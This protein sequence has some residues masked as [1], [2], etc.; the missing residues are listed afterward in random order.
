M[1]QVVSPEAD[2]HSEDTLPKNMIELTEPEPTTESRIV[3]GEDVYIPLPEEDKSYQTIVEIGTEVQYKEFQDWMNWRVK[4]ELVS[5]IFHGLGQAD[6]QLNIR[7]V[8]DVIWK[9]I[10]SQRDHHFQSAAHIENTL[11]PLAT[12]RPTARPEISGYYWQKDISN[13]EARAEI[14]AAISQR[15][16]TTLAVLG[17]SELYDFAED[18]TKELKLEAQQEALKIAKLRITDLEHEEQRN[19]QQ[20]T[21][22][23]T[24]AATLAAQLE[25]SKTA[26]ADR[27]IE[28]HEY[29]MT[30]P[31]N[32]PEQ[33]AA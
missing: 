20:M 22:L 15:I 25:K 3:R 6:L 4:N 18:Y 2:F 10:T 32:V 30:A 26:V 21:E 14:H 16:S 31:S 1:T 24:I 19:Q 13:L 33:L 5:Q 11:V 9:E 12:A 23:Q 27:D 29:E 28:L 17:D 7:S 8:R